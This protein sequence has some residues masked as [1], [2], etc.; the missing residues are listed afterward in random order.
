MSRP[1][2]LRVIGG[3]AERVCDDTCDADIDSYCLARDRKQLRFDFAGKTGIPTVGLADD[4]D[5][6][7]LGWHLPVPP[8]GYPPNTGNLQASS[9]NLVAV[10][11]F[12]Q[13]DAVE[14]VFSFETRIAWLLA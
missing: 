5:G 2:P 3:V 1:I 8:D 10:A 9:V 6:R 12:L 4:P 7:W 11:V 14:A 13:A